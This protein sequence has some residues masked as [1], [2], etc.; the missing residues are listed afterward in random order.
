MC[1]TSM[2]VDHFR[3]HYPTPNTFPSFAPMYPDYQELVRK[4]RAYDE[5]MAQ[6]D[7]PK[8]EAEAWMKD[9]EKFMREKYGLEPKSATE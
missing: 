1:A 9:V 6:K 7:C 2:I 8:P 4:A 5:M 3:Q